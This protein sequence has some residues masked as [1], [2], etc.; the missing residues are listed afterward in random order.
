MFLEAASALEQLGRHRDAIAVCEEVVNRMGDLTPETLRIDLSSWDGAEAG[1]PSPRPRS[2]LPRDI[3]PQKK[4]SLRCILWRAA[5]YLHQGWAWA[6]LADSKEA[7]T[8]FTRCRYC[9][10]REREWELT[11]LQPAGAD[12]SLPGAAGQPA[13]AAPEPSSAYALGVSPP[14][15]AGRHG[16]ILIYASGT[17]EPWGS[18]ADVQGLCRTQGVRSFRAALLSLG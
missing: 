5:A 8:Q 3:L 11:R 13:G 15:T 1:S 6:G 17:T 14:P 12:G 10:P 7:I 16:A 2:G 9:K 18:G 4:E